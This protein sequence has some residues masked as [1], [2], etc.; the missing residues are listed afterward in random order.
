MNKLGKLA[1]I[2]GNARET[3]DVKEIPVV[4]SPHLDPPSI[5]YAKC[6]FRAEEDVEN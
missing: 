2:P 3:F 1:Q 4:L 5:A 6:H